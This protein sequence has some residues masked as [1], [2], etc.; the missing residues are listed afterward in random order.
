[1]RALRL[2]GV[3]F[4]ALQLP[5][6]ASSVCT[7]GLGPEALPLLQMPELR[8]VH[9]SLARWLRDVPVRPPRPKLARRDDA[10]TMRARA[11]RRCSAPSRSAPLRRRRPE[12]PRLFVPQHHGTV[13]KPA[14]KHAAKRTVKVSGARQGAANA[15]ALLT[16]AR[17]PRPRGGNRTDSAA[18][19]GARSSTKRRKSSK[20]SRAANSTRL[21]SG[22]AAAHRSSNGS[23]TGYAAWYVARRA[24]IRT[25]GT[26]IGVVLVG[27]A[28]LLFVPLTLVASRYDRASPWTALPSSPA[29]TVGPETPELAPRPVAVPRKTPIGDYS[30]RVLHY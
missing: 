25:T 10:C 30:E 11:R 21:G 12:P 27:V 23:S 5:R 16:K 6:S 18:R 29:S 13:I 28:V 22:A 24:A 19:V 26:R 1:M 2:T 8:H 9:A 20:R 7:S 3:R 4:R 15:F 17:K 14:V